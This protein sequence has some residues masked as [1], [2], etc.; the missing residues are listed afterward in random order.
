MLGGA[1]LFLATFGLTRWRLLH[2]VAVPRLVGAAVA[3]VLMF[4]APHVPPG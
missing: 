1:A 3:L 2:T 4:V